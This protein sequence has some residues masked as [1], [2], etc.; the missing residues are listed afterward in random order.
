MYL[1]HYYEKERG[2]FRNLSELSNEESLK[3]LNLLRR[4]NK[5]FTDLQSDYLVCRKEY[6]QKAR[7]LFILKGGKPRRLVPQYM[8]VES[9]EWLNR[10][11]FE[12]EYIKINVNEFD[13][14]TISFTYGDLF[15]TFMV[16]DG[17]EYRN[18]VYTYTEIVKIIEK[19]N[20][21]QEW[22]PSG[23]PPTRYI[24]CQ[25]WSDQA[26]MPFYGI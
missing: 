3:V 12:S 9:C 15:P 5:T 8:V 7:E 25:I 22:N 23:D 10:W 13:E 11:Y 14:D 4:T 1:F 26:L 6:E 24:E 20:L 19:Y 21:P 17:M 18:Q 2:P 16:N